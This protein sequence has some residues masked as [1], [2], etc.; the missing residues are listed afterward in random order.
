[1]FS[2]VSQKILF[3][4]SQP[5]TAAGVL[6]AQGHVLYKKLVMKLLKE[7][8]AKNDPES[9]IVFKKCAQQVRLR[10]TTTFVDPRFGI[11]ERIKDVMN[12]NHHPD[13]ESGQNFKKKVI[14]VAAYLGDMG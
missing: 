14:D 3:H 5:N 7:S 4:S 12:V 1:L 2:S 6:E 13:L 8:I 10:P 11:L 9:L